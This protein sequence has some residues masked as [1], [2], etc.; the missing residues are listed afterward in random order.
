MYVCRI[1][2]AY[3]GY[4]CVRID[5]VVIL[6]AH[7]LFC[8]VSFIIRCCRVACYDASLPA[9]GIVPWSGIFCHTVTYR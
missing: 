5:S 9:G 2:S 1:L 3:D 4:R 7:L 8:S 6:K